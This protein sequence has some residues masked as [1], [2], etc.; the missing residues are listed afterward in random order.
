MVW[1]RIVLAVLMALAAVGC[2]A[3]ASGDESAGEPEGTGTEQVGAPEGSGA[4]GVLNVD[5]VQL[6]WTV[7]G[8]T[9]ALTVSAPTDGWVAVGFEPTM[10]MKDADIVMGYVAGTE[11]FVRDD[12]GDGPT[13][14]RSD[15]ELGGTDD[16]TN[17]SGSES[18]LS[19]TLSYTIPLDSGDP[20][21]HV[22]VP[23]TTVKVLLAYGREG[24][25][26]FTGYHA[27]AETVEID[28]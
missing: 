1:I 20:F 11:T 28:L 2:S 3:E 8:E 9:L 22:L 15:I 16:V 5:D 6:G 13:S 19:T 24:D 12:W 17:V 4:A 27:W 14:H 23:G 26:G 25:D 21:D 7:E 18:G 10:A